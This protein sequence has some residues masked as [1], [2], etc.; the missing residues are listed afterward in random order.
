[1]RITFICP[2]ADLS[3]GFRVIV[4]YAR[5]LRQ[6]GHDVLIMTRPPRK[7]TLREKL[8]SVFKQQPLPHHLQRGPSHLDGTDI[9]HLELDR[10]RVPTPHDLPDADVIIATW[11]E[12]AEW[13]WAMP[14]SKGAKVYFVQHHEVFPGQPVDRVEAT[15]RLPIPKICVAQ[16]LVDLCRQ[17]SDASSTLVLNS[18][19]LEQF[20][21][22]PRGK[23][24]AP[25]VGLMYSPI[26]F[27]G[28]DTSLKAF[29]I[30][31]QKIPNLRL[32]AFG[33]SKPT[34]ELPLPASAQFTLCP[35]QDQIKHIYAAAD[36]WLFESRSEGFGL[37]ILESMACRTPV[38]G[39]PAGAAPD[40]LTQGGGVLVP[41]DDAQ[42][43]ADAILQV[44]NMPEPAWRELSEAAYRT[45]G[46]YTWD[47]A[48]DRFEAALMQAAGKSDKTS[49]SGVASGLMP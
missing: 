29:D 33:S 43:M 8:R 31:R 14:P 4:T 1:M 48:T 13:V 47:D 11:W 37:P 20:S 27:K 44:C 32:V 35:A 6:R 10:A 23:Q 12:T 39:T 5:R 45:A 7:P 42:A 25:T 15:Y 46:R 19:D 28:C 3:G 30:A 38:I 9:P 34:A 22:P 21:V 24:S 2:I 16:W 41:M 36:V 40:L 17:R 49:V 26:S 18:V